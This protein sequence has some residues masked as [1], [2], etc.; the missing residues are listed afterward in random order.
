MIIITGKKKT[1]IDILF[2]K[3]LRGMNI[4]INIVTI[5]EF[6][7][8]IN[9]IN[10]RKIIIMPQINKLISELIVEYLFLKHDN[11]FILARNSFGKHVYK[12]QYISKFL[13][14]K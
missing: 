2:F 8:I 6:V 14:A 5:E 13:E 10:D 9:S 3:L 1:K 4:S 11:L 12:Y 7:K